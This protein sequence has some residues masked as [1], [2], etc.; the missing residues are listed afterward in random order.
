MKRKIAKWL[1]EKIVR[2]LEQAITIKTE[3][4]KTRSFRHGNKKY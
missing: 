1:W 3:Y 2:S 4:N